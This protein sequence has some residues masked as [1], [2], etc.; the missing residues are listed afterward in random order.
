MIVSK[1]LKFGKVKIEDI[2]TPLFNSMSKNVFNLIKKAYEKIEF[3]CGDKLALIMLSHNDYIETNT[4]LDD[5]DAIPDMPL[6]I[7]DVKFSIVASE[8]DKGYFRVSFRSKGDISARAVAETFGG[9]GHLN[10]S[11]CKI[12]GSFNEVKQRLIDSTLEVLGWKND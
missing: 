8:D 12:F 7:N 3:L 10:A 6:Q 5:I 9:G 1:L 2:T 4:K 11:G